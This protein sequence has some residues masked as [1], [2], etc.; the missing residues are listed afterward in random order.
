MRTEWEFWLSPI[1]AGTRLV[2]VSRW[3][4]AGPVGFLML[5]LHRR[6]HAPR[7]NRRTLARLKEV[8]EAERAARRREVPV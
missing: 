6:R 7:E 4:P 3:Q 2:R 5:N 1:E 8:L